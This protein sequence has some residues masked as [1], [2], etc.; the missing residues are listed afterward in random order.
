MSR[1]TFGHIVNHREPKGSRFVLDAVHKARMS[2]ADFGF[3]FAERLSYQEAMKLYPQIDVLLEQFVIGWYG[4]QACEFALMG[5]PVV[6]YLRE[7]DG[8]PLV[9]SQLWQDIPFINATPDQ[10]PGVIIN[11][12]KMSTLALTEL[13]KRGIAFVKKYHS[14]T[15]VTQQVMNE[16]LTL[17]N[18]SELN[19]SHGKLSP[20]EVHCDEKGNPISVAASNSD[21]P[22]L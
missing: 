11:I 21:L 1:L 14:N 20:K 15:V 9:P 22:K 10:I 6:V 13:G 16:L 4:L 5:K 2:G 17:P 8:P 18:H 7:A 12:T 3:I 19:E